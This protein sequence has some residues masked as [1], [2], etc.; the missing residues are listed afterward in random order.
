MAQTPLLVKG[1]A[2]K[3]LKG[4]APTAILEAPIEVHFGQNILLDGQRSASGGA[5][6]ITK[7]LWTA[8]DC[9]TNRLA[10]NVP[11]ETNT[12]TLEVTANSAPSLCK[13]QLIVQ[14]SAGARSQPT[15]VEVIIKD[16]QIPTARLQAPFEIK[17][18]RGLILDAQRS[19]DVSPGKI[20]RYLWNSLDCR[21]NRVNPGSPLETSA[22]TL[23]LLINTAPNLCQFQLVVIDNAGNRSAP[24][25]V[26]VFVKDTQMPTAVIG[27]QPEVRL[28]HPVVL[29]GRRSSD[30]TP[31]KI[32]KHLWTSLDCV[33]DKLIPGTP[34]ET[35]LPTL[36]VKI[37]SPGRCA[38]EL[39]VIDDSG[40][41]SLPD[42][43]SVIVRDPKN[44]TAV[45]HVPPQVEVGRVFVLDGRRSS[46]VG[47]AKISGYVWTSLDCPTDKLV[48]GTPLETTTATLE[49]IGT[50]V[51]RCRFEL[52]AK[53]ELQHRSLPDRVDVI[54]RNA[55][56]LTAVLDA[57]PQVELGRG[58]I[59]D[60][61]RSS[62][63]A[64]GKIAKYRWTALNCSTHQLIP[65][66]AMETVTP[67]LEVKGGA[68]GRCTFELVVTSDT[69]ARSFPDKVDVIV[70]D[71]KNPTAV[72][73]A[74]PQV[75]LDRGFILDGRRS[76]DIA[77]GKI[78]RYVWTSLN[79]GT[80]RL[81]PG[82]PLEISEPSLEL[83]GTAAGRCAFELTVLDNSGSRSLPDR[84]DVIVRDTKN[85][86]AVLDLPPQVELGRGFILDGRRSSDIAPGKI[87]K[88]LWVSL[89]CSTD[90][91]PPGTPLETSEPSLELRGAAAGRCTFELTVEND[92]AGRSLPDRVDLIIRDTQNTTF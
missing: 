80:D 65:G 42:R 54:L 41:R 33:T 11:L 24:S 17:F 52:I 35:A 10:P 29:D 14:N 69:G 38:F 5:A 27:I 8:I 26:K 40:N 47:P 45:L 61:R 6:Y 68:A 23:E 43:I 4:T 48:P 88:Y 9:A 57:P 49:I 46:A 87:V 63:I 62:D 50:A 21:T 37:G 7:Y 60:G 79:C 44:P 91:L 77:P 70:R 86:T 19:S 73:D 85:P 25:T 20:T 92:S 16:T 82:T 90:R 31:G 71:A 28:S 2:R 22:P 32:V 53:N 72:L 64:P 59:L 1:N 30:V 55:Q 39:V 67:I 12:P 84:V 15:I 76:S 34:H 74:P 3:S 81:S 51:G 78:T 56:N 89:N 36:E 18:G 58:F 13:F 83:K 66:A 75:E